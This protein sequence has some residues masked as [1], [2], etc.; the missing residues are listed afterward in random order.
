VA[1]G[2]AGV[3]SPGCDA[4]LAAGVTVRNVNTR[5]DTEVVFEVQYNGSISHTVPAWLL[6][7]TVSGQSNGADVIVYSRP[8]SV[9]TLTFDRA[10]NSTHYFLLL[11]GT[12]FGPSV[13]SDS[14]EDDVSVTIA[15]QACATLTMLVVRVGGLGVCVEGGGLGC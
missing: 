2:V 11:T 14:C 10:P 4:S 15:G 9:P 3:A 13:R 1:V 6:T 12:D 7:I 5:S 8:P